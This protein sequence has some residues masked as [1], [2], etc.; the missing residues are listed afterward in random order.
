MLTLAPEGATSGAPGP[1]A[2][3]ELQ[4]SRARGSPGSRTAVR[5]VVP[6]MTPATTT[7]PTAPTPAAMTYAGGVARVSPGR[8]QSDDIV[9]TP[10]GGTSAPSHIPAMRPPMWAA[11]SIAPPDAKPNA[12]LM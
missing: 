2:T 4:T 3:G 6:K 9:G 10:V 11:L 12:M 8:C 1:A 7:T 5:A